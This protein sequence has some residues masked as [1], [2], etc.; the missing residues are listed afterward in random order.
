MRIRLTESSH[1]LSVLYGVMV[2]TL[3]ADGGSFGS[4]PDIATMLA[5]GLMA[6][7]DVREV[8]WMKMSL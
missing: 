8:F 4:N 3:L 2:S 1:E 7:C 6:D 5:I